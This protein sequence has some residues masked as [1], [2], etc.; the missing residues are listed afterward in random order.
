M[1]WQATF[2]LFFVWFLVYVYFEWTRTTQVNVDVHVHPTRDEGD[3]IPHCDCCGEP[4]YDDP[5]LD[6]L[7]NGFAHED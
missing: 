4:I 2:L 6:A 7:D 3:S 5:E 1:D